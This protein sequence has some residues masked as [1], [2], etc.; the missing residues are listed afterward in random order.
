V[1][2]DQV[3]GRLVPTGK[4]LG[5]P[6]LASL[7]SRWTTYLMSLSYDVI[8]EAEAGLMHMYVYIILHL[9]KQPLTYIELASP[10]AHPAK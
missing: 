9:L 8:V 3:M 6:L 5:T 7:P 10:T 4:R 1:D 2:A